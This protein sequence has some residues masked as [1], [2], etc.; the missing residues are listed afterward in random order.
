M[1]YLLLVCGSALV[2][3]LWQCWQLAPSQMLLGHG[4]T[5]SESSWLPPLEP[6]KVA[7]EWDAVCETS[8]MPGDV[9]A[10]LTLSPDMIFLAAAAMG[11]RHRAH[12]IAM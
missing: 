5:G 4:R 3:L 7:I 10:G 1:M 11:A 9:S 12:M 8:V 6:E 2:T